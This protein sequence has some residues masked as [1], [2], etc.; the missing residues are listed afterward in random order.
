MARAPQL[1]GVD[2]RLDQFDLSEAT[3][4]SPEEQA[5]GWAC[6]VKPLDDCVA[7]GDAFFACLDGSKELLNDE[8][9]T[10]LQSV[11]H[12]A[13]S[14][15]RQEGDLFTPPSARHAYV[16]KLRALVKEEESVRAKRKEVF[17]SKDFKLSAPGSLFPHSWTPSVELSNAIEPARELQERLEYK[18][19]EE[20]VLARVVKTSAPVFDKSTEDGMRF[21]IYRAGS[22]EVRTMQAH[23][24]KEAVGA[25]FS[26]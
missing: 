6:D 16:H 9:R 12:P 11:F 5:G 24:N 19:Q 20:V 10:L 21:R 3:H 8:D 17:A 2:L 7:V 18:E 14:D 15:R 13:L 26:C 23:E 25:I 1:Q 22:L 4:M